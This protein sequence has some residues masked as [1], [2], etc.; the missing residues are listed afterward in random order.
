MFHEA[1][2]FSIAFLAALCALSTALSMPCT[3]DDR[4]ATEY[5]LTD[6]SDAGAWRITSLHGN[7]GSSSLKDRVLSCDFSG[8]PGYVGIG[9]GLGP[10]AGKPSEV[11]LTFES[12]RSGHPLVLRFQDSAGQY[13]QKQVAGLD[14][15]GVQTVRVPLADMGKWY[16]FGGANDGVVRQPVK[17][18]EVIVDHD[19]PNA[20]V[21]LMELR[22]ST[23]ISVEEGIVFE[24]ASRKQESR[25]DILVLEWRS[26]LPWEVKG[27]YAWQVTD[28]YGKA[29]GSGEEPVVLPPG[30]VVERTLKVARSGVKLCE[31]RLSADVPIG[32]LLAGPPKPLKP[33]AQLEPVTEPETVQV[34]KSVSTS[35][36]ELAPGGSPKLIPDSPFGMGIYLGQRWQSAEMEKP[37]RMAQSMGIKWMRDELNWA[38]LEP[39]KGK[40]NW[41]RFDTSVETAT[42]HGISI[43]GLLC[44][45]APW[46]KPH[47][48]EGIRDYCDYVKTV[49]NRYKDRVKYWEIWNE[50]NIFFWTG[51][52]EQYAELLKAAYDAVKEAD[53]D[54]KV[55]GCCTAGTDLKFIEKVFE[56]GGFDKMDILSIHP[57]RYP[58]TPEETDFIG[59]LKRADALVRKYGAPKEIWI[60]EIGWPT[61]VGGNGSSE[62]KQAAMIA[63]T[64]LQSIASGVVQ[65]V[66]WY[67]YR[68]DGLDVF[69]NE[70][71]FGV[72]RRDHSPKPACVAFRTMTRCLEA[73][74]FVK[75]LSAT[76]GVYAYLFEGKSGRTIAAWCTWEMGS[77]TLR[78]Q[79]SPVTITNLMGKRVTVRPSSETV[80][81]RLSGNPVFIAGVDA[82]AKITA[83]ETGPVTTGTG[84][85]FPAQP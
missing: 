40:W 4:V 47:T 64:Y 85:P 37:A 7:T 11:S 35:A 2:S 62:A 44:Y 20:S 51:T 81:V 48:E 13:F 52:V 59:E 3:A 78:G 25:D 22:A 41:E 5:R 53:P 36:V 67:N 79:A 46:A 1:P 68:N 49:V 17:L 14:S 19:G 24:L 82:D 73:K 34:T 45:W 54:A 70:H 38:H 30:E 69:Y 61:N 58:P 76:K 83:S 27:R 55:I 15:E 39:E 60:T 9:G 77:L 84:V 65:K 32:D 16:H 74:K 72:I 29:L 80:S 21:R 56:C 66:F 6:F 71:N 75:D 43:F 63:R 12:D 8:E 26:I 23:E 42:R 50:P 57:Y 31:F 33:R 28:F 10:I 18:A